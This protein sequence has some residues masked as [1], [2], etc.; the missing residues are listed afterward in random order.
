[1]LRNGSGFSMFLQVLAEFRFKVGFSGFW[2]CCEGFG[3]GTEAML[4]DLGRMR[5]FLLTNLLGVEEF[6]DFMRK[7]SAVDW[8][9]LVLVSRKSWNSSILS[10]VLFERFSKLLAIIILFMRFCRLTD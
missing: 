9:R 7:F 3:F 8:P 2:E 5:K 4:P 6:W 1:M 10:Q